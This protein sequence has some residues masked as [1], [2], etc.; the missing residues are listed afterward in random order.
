MNETSKREMRDLTPPRDPAV[1]LGAGR[2][3]PKTDAFTQRE[4]SMKK[5]LQYQ[6]GYSELFWL[7]ISCVL[8]SWVF[9]DPFNRPFARSFTG[10]GAISDPS[11]NKNRRLAQFH[12]GILHCGKSRRTCITAMGKSVTIDGYVVQ[13]FG[14]E[15][16]PMSITNEDGVIILKQTHEEIKSTFTSNFLSTALLFAVL[17]ST[18]L[19]TLHKSILRK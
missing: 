14:K 15:Y 9:S 11:L 17:F 3:D 4:V 2:P 13:I 18:V 8:V 12:D 10:S 7:V 1:K 6:F 5:F 16:F 19:S